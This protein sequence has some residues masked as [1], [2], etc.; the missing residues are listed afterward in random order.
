MAPLRDLALALL[1]LGMGAAADATPVWCFARLDEAG[2]G[3][4]CAEPLGD[5]PVP[6]ADCCLNPAY[7]Y[8][9]RPRGHCHTCRSDKPRP[10]RSPAPL[11]PSHL[12]QAPPTPQARAHFG[13]PEACPAPWVKPRPLRP[14]HP[15]PPTKLLPPRATPTPS[16]AHPEPRPPRATPTPSHAHTQAPPPPLPPWGL[17]PTPKPRPP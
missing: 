17:A 1:L 6:L 12:P 4:A 11:S 14:A 7:G 2:E 3:G 10:S 8:K 9:L 13:S 5:D 15:A 16:P